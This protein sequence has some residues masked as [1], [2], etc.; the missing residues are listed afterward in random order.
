MPLSGALKQKTFNCH[1]CRKLFGLW[2]VISKS[3]YID[4]KNL[5]V[6]Y[7]S[8]KSHKVIYTIRFDDIIYIPHVTIFLIALIRG[9]QMESSFHYGKNHQKPYFILVLTCFLISFAFIKIEMS[10]II[11]CQRKRAKM[12]WNSLGTILHQK[13]YIEYIVE[14][15]RTFLHN[16]DHNRKYPNRTYVC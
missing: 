10:T 5:H 4:D 6:P 3:D 1:I 14:L 13:I 8:T 2:F 15:T 9:F 11:Y 7:W 12:D 16:V